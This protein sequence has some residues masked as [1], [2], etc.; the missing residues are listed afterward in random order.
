MTDTVVEQI[1]H[2]VGSA[3][4]FDDLTLLAL[5]VPANHA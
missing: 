5:H 1:R 4:A 2:H 3:D